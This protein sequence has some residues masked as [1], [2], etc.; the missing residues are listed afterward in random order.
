[1]NI[2]Q[3]KLVRDLLGH[4]ARYEFNCN[5]DMSERD[6]GYLDGIDFAVRIVR[7]QEDSGIGQVKFD[8]DCAWKAVD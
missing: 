3:D 8:F 5:R 4:K 7:L 2:D 1:M 6:R